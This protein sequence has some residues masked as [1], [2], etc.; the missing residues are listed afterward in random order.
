MTHIFQPRHLFIIRSQPRRFFVTA[1]FSHDLSH[2]HKSVLKRLKK[3]VMNPA[4]NPELA[5]KAAEGLGYQVSVAKDATKVIKATLQKLKKYGSREEPKT[6]ELIARNHEEAQVLVRLFESL[7]TL[8]PYSGNNGDRIKLG[9]RCIG[10]IQCL[11]DNR[12]HG[13]DVFSGSKFGDHTPVGVMYR[14]L[15]RYHRR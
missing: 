15:R 14:N 10:F 9:Q 13:F 2:I 12:Y 11:T 3:I 6:N 7:T 8:Q 5:A 4:T 1:A